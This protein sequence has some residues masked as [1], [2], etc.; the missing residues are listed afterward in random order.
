MGASALHSNT[1]R[2]LSTIR[3]GLPDRCYVLLRAFH[4]RLNYTLYSVCP[5]LCL[6]HFTV[7]R[8]FRIFHT[9]YMYVL[10]SVTRLGGPDK[11]KD[12]IF[13]QCFTLLV[14]SFDT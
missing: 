7:R 11:I 14:G 8:F 5:F 3:L 13:L 2:R 12:P 1:R 10:F 6:S 4:R 9:A